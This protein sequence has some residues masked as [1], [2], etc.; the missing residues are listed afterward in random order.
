VG[1]SDPRA[2]AVAFQGGAPIRWRYGCR[3]MVLGQRCSRRGANNG[4]RMRSL[5]GRQ[6]RRAASSAGPKNSACRR[7]CQYQG[8][9]KTVRG[10]PG[11]WTWNGHRCPPEW[12]DTKDV[13]RWAGAKTYKAWRGPKKKQKKKQ[14]KKP[15][16]CRQVVSVARA[17]VSLTRG[18]GQR[19]RRALPATVSAGPRALAGIQ[20]G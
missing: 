20:G 3:A 9:P 10:A 17:N 13:E 11:T 18:E 15:S 6:T 8:L 7:G 2:R 1:A 4:G 14:K 16:I 19:R 5:W 12:D